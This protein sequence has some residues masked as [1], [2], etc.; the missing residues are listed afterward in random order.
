MQLPV[1]SETVRSVTVAEVAGAQAIDLHTHL[2]P[3]THGALCLWGIDE[4]LTYVRPLCYECPYISSLYLYAG[5][6]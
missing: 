4:L 3:P 5:I 6:M 2:L 1:S